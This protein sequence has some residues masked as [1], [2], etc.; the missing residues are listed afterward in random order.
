MF[1][2]S[3]WLLMYHF[4]SF[5]S[6][7]DCIQ[8]SLSDCP[9]WT[10]GH[11]LSVFVN[12]NTNNIPSHLAIRDKLRNPELWIPQITTAQTWTVSVDSIVWTVWLFSP[13]FP[14]TEVVGARSDRHQDWLIRP[15]WRSV[16][17]WWRG[18]TEHFHQLIIGTESLNIMCKITDSHT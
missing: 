15:A 13:L 17:I 7:L 8:P 3:H 14:L 1:S 11:Y 10:T 9:L 2:L 18:P 16:Q 6:S 12:I 4:C 5:H